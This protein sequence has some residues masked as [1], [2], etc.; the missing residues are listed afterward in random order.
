MND[1][2]QHMI[3]FDAYINNEMSKEERLRFEQEL[4]SDLILAQD[5]EAHKKFLSDFNEGVNY[6]ETK[7]NLK[8]IHKSI[9]NPDENFFFNRKFYIPLAVAA[10]FIFILLIFNPVIKEG[11]TATSVGHDE[12]L[13]YAESTDSTTKHEDAYSPSVTEVL[14][15]ILT[16][17]GYIESKFNNAVDIS[18]SGTAFM[19]SNDGYFLTAKHLVAGNKVVHL[20]QKNATMK[21]DVE[22]V[23][24]DPVEDF[25]ILKCAPN[26]AQSF[27]EIPYR[28]IKNQPHIQQAVFTLSYPKN[29]LQYTLGELNSKNGYFLDSFKFKSPSAN[30]HE[31]SGAPLFSYNGELIGIISST[32]SDAKSVTYYVNQHYIQNVMETLRISDSIY[33][34]MSLNYNL[35]PI[36]HGD[37]IK[38]Y[39]PFIFELHP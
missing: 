32:K 31:Y 39:A 2:G 33:I 11:S 9:Y 30:F 1:F 29:E 19:I 35:R 38:S 26:V 12:E 22:V 18:Y 10:S 4:N 20:Q 8:S 34:N 21:F 25:A 13:A 23:Y 16:D 28:F 5:F 14:D 7:K 36:K 3:K 15:T 6:R 17:K 24:V 37:F 27:K